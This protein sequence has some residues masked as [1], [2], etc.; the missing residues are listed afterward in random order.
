MA[1][2]AAAVIR[3]TALDK[4]TKGFQSVG[5]G[6]KSLTS[7]VFSLR[8][9]LIAAAGVGGFAFLTKRSMNATDQLAK[10]ASK[11]GATTEALSGLRY[12]A[13]LTGVSAQTM[14]MAM[15]RFARR[16]AEAAQGT[17]EAKGAIKELGIDAKELV[18]MPLDERMVVLA[19]AFQGVSTESDKLRLAFKLFD[20]EGAALV[21]TLG[22]G[23]DGLRELLNEAETLGL[24]MSGSAAAGVE[25]ANDELTK[26]GGLF[27]GVT[28]QTVA[29]FA[30]AIETLTTAF[31]DYLLEVVETDGGVEAFAQTLAIRIMGAI[32]T[33][34]SGL[35]ALANGFIKVYNAALIMKDNLTRA[36]TSDMEKNARQLSAE[37]DELNE[38]LAG[39]DVRQQV[40]LAMKERLK[41]LIELRDQ[42]T[43]TGESL[44]TLDTV[45]FADVLNAKID[46]LKENIRTIPDA[47]N[48]A[49]T[50]NTDDTESKTEE[51]IQAEKNLKEFELKSATEKTRHVTSELGKQFGA[52]KGQSKKMFAISKAMNIATAIMD[53]YKGANVA[54]GSY[55]PPLNYVMAAGVIAGGL[56]NVAQIRSQSFEGG[57]FTG[58]GA[59]TGG[60]DGKGGFPAILHPNET[61]ID[62]TKSNGRMQSGGQAVVVNQ[63][64]NISTGVAQTVRA[65]MVN[66]MPQIAN[67]AKSAVADARQRGGSYSQAIIGA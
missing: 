3:I 22:L 21:N 62:H 11:I 15:Q 41:K 31:K 2:P 65:E 23:G 38:K 16:T 61:V 47:V 36:F 35:Q 57:G 20:S 51:Q 4:T 13:D 42:A 56:A 9:A 33:A 55:P 10:T 32:Q 63:T 43:E 28:D 26:L 48:E 44:Q 30:P 14:D 25:K 59:R 18:K 19:D 40:R 7:S 27:R 24:V 39:D 17:G 52:W 49:N 64:I 67:A 1:A 58:H 53:T 60:V 46:E 50:K 54:L 5:R 66:L 34:L 45:D 29:A 12:A 37:I 6:L 8:T